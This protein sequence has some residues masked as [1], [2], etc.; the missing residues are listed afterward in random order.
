MVYFVRME[1]TMA[2]D[3][4]RLT[5]GLPSKAAKMRTLEAAGA[6]RSDIA[7]YLDVSYQQ[8]RN[9]LLRGKPTRAGFGEQ[10]ATFA[11]DDARARVME[12]GSIRIPPA[13]AAKI[14][15]TVNDVLVLVP[16]E[17]GLWIAT[18]TASRARARAFAQ[19]LIP[20]GTDWMKELK[21]DR[22]RQYERE[23]RLAQPSKR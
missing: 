18:R 11:G 21:E 13:I 22:R 14:G 3:W 17:G 19:G 1:D 23:E 10:A 2:H 5:A 20:P 15:A 9:T 7:R 16:E 12:D 8:V 4:D 6:S